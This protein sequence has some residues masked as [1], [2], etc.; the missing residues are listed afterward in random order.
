MNSLNEGSARGGCRRSS[1]GPL[2]KFC[3]KKISKVKIYHLNFEIF[4]V[5]P[6]GK[7]YFANPA[8]NNNLLL[9]NKI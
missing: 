7:G 4:I 5:S 8:L 3:G 9:I 1:V 2:E 6:S